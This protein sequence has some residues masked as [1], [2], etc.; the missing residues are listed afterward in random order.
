MINSATNLDPIT[1]EKLIT[2]LFQRERFILLDFL[3]ARRSDSSLE[4]FAWGASAEGGFPSTGNWRWETPLAT[5]RFVMVFEEQLIR[6]FN[7][8]A[9]VLYC[10]R[11]DKLP[12]LISLPQLG[13]MSLKFGTVQVLAPHAIVA[14][15]ES[16]AMIINHPCGIDRPFEVSIALVVVQLEFQCFHVVY[17]NEIKTEWQVYGANLQTQT[18]FSLVD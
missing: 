4:K 10:L 14:F 7:S 16:H 1:S 9:D 11:A 12:K 17:Y 15:V 6:F 2:C 5:F 3:E 8:L 18:H 13:N